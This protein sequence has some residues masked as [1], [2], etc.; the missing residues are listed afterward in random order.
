[1][2]HIENIPPS[3]CTGC[4]GCVAVCPKD[5][6][7][8]GT[9]EYGS[10]RPQ[11]DE[12]KCIHCQRCTQFCAKIHAAPKNAPSQVYGA[13]G[14]DPDLV[15][16]SA[17]GGVFAT[18][19]SALVAQKGQVYGAVS[20]CSEGKLQVYHTCASDAREMEK[21]QGSK[22]VQSRAWEV[23]RA[24]SHSLQKGETVLFTGTPCQVAAVKA[25]TGDPENLITMDLVCHGVPAAQ[26]L[27]EALSLFAKRLGGKVADFA[28]RDK[29][30]EKQYTSRLVLRKGRGTKTYFVRARYLSFYDAF[31]KSD[32][33][34]ESC[35]SCRYAGMDRVSDLTVGDYWGME[36]HHSHQMQDRTDWSCVLVNTEK[37]KAFL[38]QYGENLTLVESKPQWAAEENRQLRAPS[39]KGAGRARLLELY[40]KGGY[41][42]VEKAFVKENGGA[43]RYRL[44]LYRSLK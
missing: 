7:K 11:I 39:E 37:G 8:M 36:K 34:R 9:D 26:M 28:F 14:N 19:A 44:R 21:M 22:Y 27:N 3:E 5:A 38:S 33:L 16:K 2:M 15:R 30:R 1:M 23:Y 6:V 35:Y 43:L 12:H 24:V 25:Y 17:S 29:S 4:G 42:A 10:F 32:N 18:V 31:L 41:K 20:Q 13:V 40:K